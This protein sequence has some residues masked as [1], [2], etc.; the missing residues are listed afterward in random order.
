MALTSTK[1]RKKKEKTYPFLYS[2]QQ[3]SGLKRL[4]ELCYAANINFFVRGL[5]LK[6]KKR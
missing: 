2:L 3:P 6:K 1:K 4:S 5:L